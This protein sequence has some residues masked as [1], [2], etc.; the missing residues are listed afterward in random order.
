MAYAKR[1]PDEEF[2]RLWMKTHNYDE[3]VEARGDGPVF[4]SRPSRPSS[5]SRC[6]SSAQRERKKDDVAS[7][8]EIIDSYTHESAKCREDGGRKARKGQA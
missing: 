1:V 8:N 4:D 6:S 3:L 2:V 7:L 5:S